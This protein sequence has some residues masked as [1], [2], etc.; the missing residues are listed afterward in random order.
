MLVVVVVSLNHAQEILFTPSV[1]KLQELI[2]GLN[3]I[4]Y[5]SS[6]DELS[7]FFLVSKNSDKKTLMN[8]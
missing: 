6:F 3:I 5:L 4:M 8:Q 2:Q 7:I 1:F